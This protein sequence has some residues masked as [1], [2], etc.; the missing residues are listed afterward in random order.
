MKMHRGMKAWFHEF[1]PLHQVEVAGLLHVP[2]KELM[3]PIGQEAE[4]A[5][6]PI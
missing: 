5:P 1:L 4:W 2:A 3:I 6:E